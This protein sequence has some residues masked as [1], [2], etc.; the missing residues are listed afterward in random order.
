MYWVIVF[1]FT[2]H[3]AAHASFFL[4][5]RNVDEPVFL[6]FTYTPTWKS[7]QKIEF[8][9]NFYFTFLGRFLKSA[10][11]FRLVTSCKIS[12]SL[13]A[14]GQ[15]RQESLALAINFLLSSFHFAAHASAVLFWTGVDEPVF[16]DFTYTPTWKSGQKIELL[17]NF[18]FTFLGRFLKSAPAFRLVVKRDSNP[19]FSH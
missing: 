16:L 18:Y 19:G 12:T 1:Q 4:F 8:H 5:W 6:D 9:S 11:A 14:G 3:I 7:G 17:S 15:T 13:Q 10:P 2:F